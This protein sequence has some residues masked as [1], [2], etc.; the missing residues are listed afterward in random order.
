MS[1]LITR[2]RSTTLQSWKLDLKAA[3]R[4]EQLERALR[5]ISLGSDESGNFLGS[6]DMMR[7]AD[8]ALDE[9]SKK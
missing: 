9:L 6:A 7:L 4:I 5:A 8:A 2:L 3:D 1:D